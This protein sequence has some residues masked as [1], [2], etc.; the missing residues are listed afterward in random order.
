MYA[1][2]KIATIAEKFEKNE[3]NEKKKFVGVEKCGT[4]KDVKRIDKVI[5]V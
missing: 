5:F 4:T 3:Y 2:W 1:G